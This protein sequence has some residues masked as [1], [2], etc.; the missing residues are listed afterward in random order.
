MKEFIMKHPVATVFLAMI[1][2]DITANGCKLIDNQLERRHHRK[3][4]EKGLIPAENKDDET[5]D[6]EERSI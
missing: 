1:G 6:K 5:D 3:L 4:L 2:Y